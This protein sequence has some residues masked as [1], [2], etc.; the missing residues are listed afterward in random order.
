MNA[1]A[2]PTR[3]RLFLPRSGILV[4]VVVIFKRHF[5]RVQQALLCQ[6]P[7]AALEEVT[8]SDGIV[9][10]RILFKPQVIPVRPVPKR[11]FQGWRYLEEADSPPDLPK[12]AKVD[13]M[14]EKMRRELGELG[15][16]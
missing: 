14:P 11:A 16:L 6:Q 8:G 3:S 15:L 1:H 12:S 5:E 7:I 13:G 9:R 10:C 2:A 4:T